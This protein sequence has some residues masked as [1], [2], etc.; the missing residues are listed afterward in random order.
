MLA[1]LNCSELARRR[2]REIAPVAGLV[3]TGYPGAPKGAKQLQAS[4]SLFYEVFRQYDP[5]NRLLGQAEAEVLAQELDLRRLRA[6]L[7][8]MQ[9]QQVELMTLRAP[10]PFA[11]ALMVERFREQVTT[12]KLADRLA[13]YVAEAERVLDEPQ[14]PVRPAPRVRRRANA[15]PPETR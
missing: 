10:S 11:L 6:A 9:G 2:F 5:G 1:S 12:E 3:F 4:S 14:P 7:Q 15:P 8:R 13:R